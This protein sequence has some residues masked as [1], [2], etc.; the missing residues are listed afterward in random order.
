MILAEIRKND[1][2]NAF[3]LVNRHPWQFDSCELS[4]VCIVRVLENVYLF[5]L[6]IR[7]TKIRIN[8]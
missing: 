8:I 7:Y 4:E 1:S 5:S 6:G 2:M 3:N